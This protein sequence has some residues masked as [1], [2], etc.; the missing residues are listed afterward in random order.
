MSTYSGGS[1]CNKMSKSAC[2]IQ[3]FMH[4]S[5]GASACM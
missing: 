3:D 5:R 4:T 2:I 1:D